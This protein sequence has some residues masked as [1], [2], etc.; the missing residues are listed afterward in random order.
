MNSQGMPL[1]AFVTDTKNLVFFCCCYLFV[2][3]NLR[4]SEMLLR[5][6]VLCLH[7]FW[8]SF[9]FLYFFFAGRFNNSCK[10]WEVTEIF[11][12]FMGIKVVL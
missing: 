7:V 1:S 10:I 11:N 6:Q 12:G 4:G 8:T 5:V 3:L 2:S 9:S